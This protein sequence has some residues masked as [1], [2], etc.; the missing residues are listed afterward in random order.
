VTPTREGHFSGARGTELFRRSWLPAAPPRAVVVLVH[1]LGDH[2][3]LYAPVPARLVPAG[4]ALES[5]DLRGH[6]RSPGKRGHLDS[7]AE[8]RADLLALLALVRGEH[9]GAPVFLL[10]HSAGGLTV[11]ELA[12]RHPDGLAGVVAASPAIG[13]LGVPAWLLLLA[14]VLARVWPSFSLD[15][16]LEIANLSRDPAEVRAI[17]EDPLYHT[18]GT[19]RAGAETLDAIAWTR[20]HAGELR[21]PLLVLH[22]TADRI[23]S[24]ESSRAFFDAAGSADKTYRAYPGAFHNLFREMNTAEVL[25]DVGA[26]LDRQTA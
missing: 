13:D 25:D 20:A 2:S 23:T 8:R 12:L 6:G 9:P 3:G 14:R 4:Y 21:L 24:P 5:C 17:V 11:L 19:A 1:G 26:W 22:G 15:A 16:Q 18:R 7:W 10:G